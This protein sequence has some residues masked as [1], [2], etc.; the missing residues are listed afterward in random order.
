ML[1]HSI[2]YKATIRE[3]K[4]EIDQ[5]RDYQSPRTAKFILKMKEIIEVRCDYHDDI[6]KLRNF[7]FED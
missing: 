5:V 1:S 6:G 7:G 3:I 2:D 4:A